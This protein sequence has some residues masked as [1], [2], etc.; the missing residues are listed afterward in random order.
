MIESN[1]RKIVNGM[2]FVLC[3]LCVT[4]LFGLVFQIGFGTN[5]N[6]E[7][8]DYNVWNYGIIYQWIWDG[9]PC[10]FSV[11]FYILYILWAPIYFLY[12]YVRKKV[13]GYSSVFVRIW[14]FVVWG[15]CNW[16]CL[17]WITETNFDGMMLWTSFLGIILFW[18]PIVVV[19]ESIR[20]IIYHDKNI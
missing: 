2:Y 11:K 4:F 14:E 10:V 16:L 5:T 6:G 3:F 1:T 17:L 12:D 18:L 9:M 13:S 15:L 19:T 8:C 20:Y 7:V